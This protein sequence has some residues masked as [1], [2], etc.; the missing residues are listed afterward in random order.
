MGFVTC[1]NILVSKGGFHTQ[2]MTH[3]WMAVPHLRYWCW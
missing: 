2:P 1:V 3:H